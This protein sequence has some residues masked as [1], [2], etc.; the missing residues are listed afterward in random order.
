MSSGIGEIG[1]KR[2]FETGTYTSE[3]AGA[4]REVSGRW[5]EP[6][7]DSHEP[8]KSLSG[9]EQGGSE[10]QAE[11][12]GLSSVGAGNTDLQPLSLCSP[13]VSASLPTSVLRTSD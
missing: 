8:L 3:R 9:Q 13:E 6:T 7:D 10:G 11:G 1:R 5:E 2:L 4:G 12:L